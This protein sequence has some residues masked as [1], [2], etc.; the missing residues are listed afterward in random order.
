MHEHEL[1]H[2][3]PHCD[4]RVLHE[5]GTCVFCDH[6]PE[7]QSE[8][9]ARGIN[10]TN[11]S[12]PNL[13]PC[14][15]VAARGPKSLYDW[16]NQAT[17]HAAPQAGAALAEL[18]REAPSAVAAARNIDQRAARQLLLTKA[19]QLDNINP[20]PGRIVPNLPAAIVESTARTR[21]PERDE[22]GAAVSGLATSELEDV[23][24]NE[25]ADSA[26]AESD[27]RIPYSSAR[28]AL[29]LARRPVD[30]DSI[31]TAVRMILEAIGEDL[32]RADVRDT[33]AR[34]ARFYQEFFAYEPGRVDT[35]FAAEHASDQMV[36]VSGV[37]VWSMCAHHML[38]FYVD[39]AMGYIASGRVLGLSKFA[40]IAHGVAH[41]LQ[42]QEQIA[43]EIADEIE[44]VTGTRNVAVLCENGLHT[45]AT[46][47]GIKTPL[48]MN[49]AVLRGV[50]RLRPSARTEFYNLIQGSRIR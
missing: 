7:R 22:L 38:P 24:D 3:H 17:P 11:T 10:F 21:T 9:S 37:R 13:Q 4:T 35:S 8:R 49:N 45:C 48:S 43:A 15:A 23:L 32:G 41:K 25:A 12:D 50:F 2:K 46:M 19:A 47:R 29:G 31:E 26:L 40:R 34:V 42:T 30:T 36:T 1:N 44:R 18:E 5:P 28:R 27:E 39:I 20:L 6:Y 16:C 14:P 33:P